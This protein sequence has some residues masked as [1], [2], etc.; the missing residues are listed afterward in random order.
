MPWDATN[1]DGMCGTPWQM[2]ALELKLSK[3]V[4]AGREGAGPPLPRIAAERIPEFEPR[5]FYALSA[6]IEAH[7]HTGGCPGCAALASHGR[8]TKRHNDECQERNRTIV[9][10]TLTGKTRTSAYTDRV[11]E[12]DRVKEKKRARD[13]GGAGGVPMEPGNEGQV[14]DRHAFHEANIMRCPHWQKRIG[15]RR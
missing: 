12:T 11:A 5:R 9:E 2:V 4:T 13:E 6:D 1:W 7:G 15:D 10:R 3:K 8:A 14:A